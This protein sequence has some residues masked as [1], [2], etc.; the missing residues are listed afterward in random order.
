MEKAVQTLDRTALGILLVSDEVGRL[1]GTIT[2]G[3]IRR[4]LIRHKGMQTVISD[5]MFKEPITANVYNN[6]EDILDSM[7]K[8]KILQ[9]PIINKQ[10]IV[11]DL[12]TLQQLISEKKFNTPVFLMAGGFGKRLQPMTNSMPK[13]LL[14]IGKKPILETIISQFISAGFYNF[15]ISTHYKAEMIRNYFGDGSKWNINI[16]YIHEEQPL[17]TAGALGLLPNEE[18][19]FPIIMMNGDI[20]TKINF[21]ELLKFHNLEGGDAT[22]CVRE[23]DFQVPYGVVKSDGYQIEEIIE[24]PVHKFFINAGVYVLSKHIVDE[25]SGSEY[26]DIPNFFNTLTQSGSKINMFPLH[27]YWLDIG[28]VDEFER[29]ELEYNTEFIND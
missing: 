17:G 5:F 7:K 12:I 3:D 24:K 19:M 15:Y 2:D 8:N 16:K 20:L 21:E 25:L 28:R 14:S 26:V 22:M 13:P 27:E 18:I 4:A 1:I 23:Y 11:V 9:M 6:H 29:A 10:G